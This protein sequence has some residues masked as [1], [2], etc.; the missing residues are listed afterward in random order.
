MKILFSIL[1]VSCLAA[2]AHAQNLSAGTR[3]GASY[4]LQDQPKLQEA[5]GQHI[6]FDKAVFLRYET[7]GRI[8][9]EI[10]VN[11]NR[12]KTA[13]ATGG[14]NPAY[15]GTFYYTT[16]Y[17]SFN[18]SFQVDV[19]CPHFKACPVLKKLKV[20]TGVSL[21][22]MIIDEKKVKPAS[23]SYPEIRGSHSEPA[24]WAGLNNTM[25]YE[26]NKSFLITSAF[27]VQVDPVSTF[28][29]FTPSSFQPTIRTLFQL[30]MAYK[31][32]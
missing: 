2:N 29:K 4:W 13:Y 28:S 31:L 3:L 17:T 25:N 10:G 15:G 9:Y 24:I 5:Q 23:E 21:S 1:L 22:Y 20:Y 8:A 30:G 12:L 19:S 6:S 26:L 14:F 16:N 27:N 18:T 7:K 11:H 32:N